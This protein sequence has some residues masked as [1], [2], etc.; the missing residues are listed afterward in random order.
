MV[1]SYKGNASSHQINHILDNNYVYTIY[2]F[3]S[4]SYKG[5]DNSQTYINYKSSSGASFSGSYLSTYFNDLYAGI[6]KVSSRN[7]STFIILDSFSNSVTPLYAINKTIE[8]DILPAFE[9]SIN[10]TY[11]WMA[12]GTSITSVSDQSNAPITYTEF[13]H[14]ID[15]AIGQIFINPGLNLGGSDIIHISLYRKRRF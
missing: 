9:S 11:Q 10:N 5:N 2:A 6:T 7:T 15:G 3:A 14:S 4:T 12:R 13:V 1:Y 8:I